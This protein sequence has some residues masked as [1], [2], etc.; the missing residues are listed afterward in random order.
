MLLMVEISAFKSSIHKESF[1]VFWSIKVILESLLGSVS[2]ES[3]CVFHK[4]RKMDNSFCITKMVTKVCSFTCESGLCGIW[5]IAIDQ[6]GF[7]YACNVNKNK[8]VIF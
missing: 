7:I 4:R 1:S 5:D 8:V 2:V 6:D 3:W